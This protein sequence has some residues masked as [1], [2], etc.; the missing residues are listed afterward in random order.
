MAE[1]FEIQEEEEGEE[2]GRARSKRD[3][4]CVGEGKGGKKNLY[5]KVYIN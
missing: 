5:N 2:E 4:L 3:K 1:R